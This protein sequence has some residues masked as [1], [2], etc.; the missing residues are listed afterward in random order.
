[1]LLRSRQGTDMTT[2]FPEVREAALAQLPED[3]GLD[4][5]LVV[6]ESGRLAFE[7]RRRARGRADLA[8]APG[9]LRPP[10]PAGRRPHV[11]VLQRAPD[12]PGGPVR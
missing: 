1:M 3:T 2:A 6:W 4:G 8:R 12:G 11:T 5:E 10:T 9:R 7:R